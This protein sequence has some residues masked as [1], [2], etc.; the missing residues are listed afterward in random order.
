[1]LDEREPVICHAKIIVLQQH[2]LLEHRHHLEHIGSLG[3][4]A[5][6]PLDE[7]PL[8]VDTM[9]GLVGAARLQAGK[10]LGVLVEEQEG[11][12]E[13]N[14]GE[15]PVLAVFLAALLQLCFIERALF[16]H[17]NVYV[18]YREVEIGGGEGGGGVELVPQALRLGLCF[19]LLLLLLLLRAV[20]GAVAR[21]RALGTGGA[22]VL[23]ARHGA[24]VHAVVLNR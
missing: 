14:I 10:G 23:S 12:R 24:G 13:N 5:V 15:A 9:V 8:E 2:L 7:R 1:M 19:R 21:L 20:H 17:D 18:A 11:V 3:L 6:A 22:G 4:V 16:H